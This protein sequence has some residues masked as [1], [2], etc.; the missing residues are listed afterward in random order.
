M[1]W[2]VLLSMFFVACTKPEAAREVIPYTNAFDAPLGPEWSTEATTW[3]VHDG[4]LY[5][6]GAHNKP[7]WLSATLPKDVRVRFQ[8]DP[9][10][11]DVDFKFEIFGDGKTHESGYSVMFGAW[12]NTKSVIARLGEHAPNRIAADDAL[13]RA[14]VTENALL[15]ETVN[16]KRWDATV[17][18]SVLSGERSYMVTFERRGNT[19]TVLLDDEPEP[20]MT[21]FDPS[22][23]WGPGHDRFAFS[24]WATTVFFDDLSIE[25][26]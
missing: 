17:R 15:A 5:D 9:Q 13:L 26:L 16:A 4:R 3:S 19:L 18:D 24:N 21:Y 7:L 12:H 10:T 2:I 8:V 6:T 25:A 23:L 20:F 11:A 14:K 22:P 1:R